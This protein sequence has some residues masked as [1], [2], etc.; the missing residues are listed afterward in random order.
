[1]ERKIITYFWKG[2]KILI[3]LSFIY[4]SIVMI[5]IRSFNTAILILFAISFFIVF[6]KIESMDQRLKV[7]EE[8]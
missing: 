1:M 6:N 8:D 7:L 2:L 5:K 4:T 3:F